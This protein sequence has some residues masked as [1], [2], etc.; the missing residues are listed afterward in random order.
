MGQGVEVFTAETEQG[1]LAIAEVMHRS[2]IAEI[3][4]VPP[5]WARVLVVDGVPVSFI[6]PR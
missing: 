6:H 2:Y 1:W 4:S 5:P 3:N